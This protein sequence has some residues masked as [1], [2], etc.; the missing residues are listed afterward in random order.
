MLNNE[1]QEFAQIAAKHV[2]NASKTTQK[3]KKQ[4]F[5]YLDEYNASKHLK[6]SPSLAVYI[7]S[8]RLSSYAC[9][10]T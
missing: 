1:G 5:L 9:K 3:L 8:P 2:R 6:V 4:K 7:I 10:I